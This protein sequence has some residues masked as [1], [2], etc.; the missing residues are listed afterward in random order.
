[1]TTF[2]SVFRHN[3]TVSLFLFFTVT[4]WL[5]LILALCE[6][7]CAQQD[8]AYTKFC[9]IRMEICLIMSVCN[10][11]L[12]WNICFKN[13]FSSWLF[14]EPNSIF[15]STHFTLMVIF[16]HIKTIE[17]SLTVLYLLPRCNDG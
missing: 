12:V 3:Y 6:T 2:W 14:V 17:Q 10:L 9:R 4:E 13:T 11:S 7:F 15:L 1:M 16:R 8:T 5:C